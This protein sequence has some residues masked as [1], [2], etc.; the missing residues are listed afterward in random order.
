MSAIGN[1]PV[2]WQP[3][4]GPQTTFL[5]SSA[6]E[7]LYGGAAGGGKA[8]CVHTPIPTPTGWTS[9]GAL[10][11]GDAVLDE[12]GVPCRVEW[13]S[14]VRT[15]RVCYEVVFSDGSTLIADAD[16]QWVAHNA[17]D[18]A[19][20]L[21][22]SVEWRA[23]RRSRRAQRGT[24]KRP[25][26]S[27]RNRQSVSVV[28]SETPLRVVT[29]EE[30]RQSLRVGVRANWSVPVAKPMALPDADLPVPPYVLGVWLGDGTSSAGSITCAEADRAIV[31]EVRAYGYDID[32]EPKR[33]RWGTRGLS[34]QLRQLGVL[35]NKHIPVAYLRASFEQRL[36]LLQGLMDTDGYVDARGQCEFTATNRTLM[37]GMS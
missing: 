3:H 31:D 37:D 18:R 8:L 4:P 23:A 1:R 11:V 5:A 7:C 13:V 16:H 6:Y 35:N 20:V 9:M 36:A 25:D 17:A 15:D 34:P 24:G 26:L 27:E 33:Y 29:T 2:L 32:T 21:R 10:R 30:M 14:E 19:R 22:S 12:S 28:E